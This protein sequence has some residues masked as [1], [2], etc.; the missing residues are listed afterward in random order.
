MPITDILSSTYISQLFRYYKTFT[1]YSNANQP[2]PKDASFVQFPFARRNNSRL[3]AAPG[4]LFCGSFQMNNSHTQRVEFMR[5]ADRQSAQHR[6]SSPTYPSTVAIHGARTRQKAW[7]AALHV[8]NVLMLTMDAYVPLQN[9]C[10]QALISDFCTIKHSRTVQNG[11][12]S[13]SQ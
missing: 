5:T 12:A 9:A 6:S 4:K 11:K 2:Q 3:I 1:L 10:P 8:S 13:R 7:L